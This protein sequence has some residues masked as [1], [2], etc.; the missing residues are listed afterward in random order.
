MSTDS[1]RPKEEIFLPP[2]CCKLLSIVGSVAVINTRTTSN[3]RRKGFISAYRL[4]SRKETQGRNL[5]AATKERL[6]ITEKGYFQVCSLAC[7]QPT[8]LY[9]PDPLA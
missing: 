1:L 6:E 8:F 2:L 7:V 4:K 9:S 5:K 3:L